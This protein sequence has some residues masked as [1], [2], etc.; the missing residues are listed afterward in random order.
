MNKKLRHI[1]L[2]AMPQAFL[3]YLGG[4]DHYVQNG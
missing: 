2:S 3:N 4:Y 1:F